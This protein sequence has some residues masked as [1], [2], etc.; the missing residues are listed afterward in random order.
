MLPLAHVMGLEVPQQPSEFPDT[1]NTWSDKTNILCVKR[2]ASKV[3]K[4]KS[5][6]SPG[7]LYMGAMNTGTHLSFIACRKMDEKNRLVLE[8]I[9]MLQHLQPSN[10]SQTR[11]RMPH[12]SICVP[13]TQVHTIEQ[14]DTT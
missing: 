14:L 12:N 1:F 4:C 9:C 7:S 2:K 10:C 3:N 6:L 13:C 11:T 8:S 5:Q